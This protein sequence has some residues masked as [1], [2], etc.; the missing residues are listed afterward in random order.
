[1]LSSRPLYS[2]FSASRHSTDVKI[3]IV[4]QIED[5]DPADQGWEVEELSSVG[6]SWF[7]AQPSRYGFGSGVNSNVHFIV[8]EPPSTSIYEIPQS[9]SDY[10]FQFNNNVAS[11][12]SPW[13]QQ[14]NG[15][16]SSGGFT[17]FS[18]PVATTA[19]QPR[20]EEL[21]DFVPMDTD[22]PM[23]DVTTHD[24]SSGDRAEDPYMFL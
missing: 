23:E 1:L 19:S 13:G 24:E 16:W 3:W 9:G 10:R 20:V 14:S 22:E 4:V 6:P 8:D 17:P 21:D 2:W 11:S 12:T 18:A 5:V 7:A 15:Q